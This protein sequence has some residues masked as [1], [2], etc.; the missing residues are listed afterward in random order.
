[1]A[2]KNA[3]LQAAKNAK[4]DEFFTRREDIE[5]ELRHYAN[6]F[7]GKVV[8]CNCDDPLYSEFWQFFIRNFSAWGLKKLIATH[9]EPNAENF[10]YKLEIEPDENGQFS[11]YQEPVKTALPCNG[12]FR[13]AACI[14]LLKEADIVVTNPPF[15]LFREYV[16]QL[17]EYEKQFLIIGP[18]NAVKYGEIFPLLMSDKVWLGYTCPKK[19]LLPSGDFKSFGNVMWYT[20]LDISKRHQPLDLRGNY[21]DSEKHLRYVNYDAIEVSKVSDIPCDYD[22]LMGVPISYLDKYCP[23]QFEIVGMNWSVLENAV[24]SDDIRQHHSVARRLNFYLPVPDGHGNAYSRMYDR[25]V[26]RRK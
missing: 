17:M 26:I 2:N 23:D 12:D 3:N 8:Y 11:M 20:N 16:A 21:Y 14:E 18:L 7:R 5:N 25:I 13:S 22:G 9:Y 19:F 1:M 4:N 10:S 6:H 15:S 24:L